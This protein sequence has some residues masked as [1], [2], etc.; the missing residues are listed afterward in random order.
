M[1]SLPGSDFFDHDERAFL[2]VTDASA[3][4]PRLCRRSWV[5]GP[6]FLAGRKQ[7]RGGRRRSLYQS[8]CAQEAALLSQGEEH[9]L[10]VHGGRSEPARFIRLQAEV[11]RAQR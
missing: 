2:A 1:S 7:R 6:G 10:S 3:F 11:A 8:A 9:Y 4:F 5:A